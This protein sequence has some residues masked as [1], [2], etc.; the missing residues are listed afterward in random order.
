[1]IVDLEKTGE[2]IIPLFFIA[3]I[4]FVS[5]N[6]NHYKFIGVL[7]MKKAK[8]FWKIMKYTKADKIIFGYLLF[9]IVAAFVIWL[10]EPEITRFWDSLWYCY[11]TSTT[12]G[13]GDFAAVTIVGRIASIALSIYSI[14][15]IAL[16]PGIVV[17]YFL[18]YTKV[19]TDESMLLI[20]DK[21]ENL[22]KLS[23]EELKELSTKIKKFRK[24]RGN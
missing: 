21:L 14:I 9:F 13:F 24:N 17:S 19:R 20:A 7:I 11:V 15:V 18:E 16:V 12:I 23:K 4:Y 1:M 5:Y 10:F 3:E 22:D 6:K 8:V 2:E